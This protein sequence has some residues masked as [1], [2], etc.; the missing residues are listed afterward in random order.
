[1]ARPMAAPAPRRGWA[2]PN[3]MGLGGAIAG[4]IAGLAMMVISPILALVTGI[5]IWLPPKL[6]STVIYPASVA[7]TPGFLLGPVLI[8]TAIHF[9]VSTVLG[10]I[11]GLVFNRILHLSTAFGTPI[12]VGL[13]YGLIQWAIAYWLLLPIVNPLLRDSYPGAFVAQHVVFGVVLGAVYMLVRRLP[14]RDGD[15]HTV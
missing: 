12:L 7:T 3:V 2:I 14:Y 4:L 1:M 13:M 9:G 5:D 11:F 15:G 10:L 6:I 8:G